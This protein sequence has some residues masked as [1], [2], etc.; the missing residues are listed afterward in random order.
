MQVGGRELAKTNLG[1][2][3]IPQFMGNFVI[4]RQD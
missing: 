1:R 3:F 2:K 4:D